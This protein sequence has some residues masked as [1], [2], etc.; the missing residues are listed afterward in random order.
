M[1]VSFQ[2]EPE[3][4]FMLILI[5]LSEEYIWVTVGV[6]LKKYQISPIA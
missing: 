3:S 5:L 6:I 1:K 2:L 4:M